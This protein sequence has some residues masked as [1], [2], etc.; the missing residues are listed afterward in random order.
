MTKG[1]DMVTFATEA[2]GQIYKQTTKF[3]YIGATVCKNADVTVENNRRVLLANLRLRRYGLSLYNQSTAPLWLK[4]RMLKAEVMG[5]VSYGC[6]TRS[7]SVVDLTI[8]RAAHYRWLL[9]CT[10]W[11]RKCRDGYYM[12]SYADALAETGCEN[13]DTTVRKRR[14]LFA[15]FVDS[16]DNERLPKR[17]MFGEVEGGKGYSGGQEQDW[18]GC[19]E[20]DLSLFN[21]S[22]E[23]KHWKLAAKNPGEWFRRVEESTEQYM[24]RWFVT[25][26]EH[27]AKRR[28]PEVQT[29]RQQPKTCQAQG[30]KGG[31]EEEPS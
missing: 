3:L 26:K 29:A 21:L 11:K 23:V 10:G 27:V 17:A 7:P 5:T 12:L 9:R 4:V 18:M 1:M 24:K 8:L 28:A 22:N 15:G 25:E 6:V 31:E 13:V 19:L 14:I 20:H 16:M 30:P 2:A